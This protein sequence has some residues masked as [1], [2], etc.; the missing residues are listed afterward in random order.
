V[1]AQL[2][3]VVARIGASFVVLDVGG[4]GYRV[5]VPLSVLESLPKTGEKVLLLT[6]TLVREDD[7]SLYG[8][9]EEI[10]LKVFELLLTVSGVGPKVALAMLSALRAEEVARAV[11]SDDVKTLTRVPGIGPKVAQRLVLELRERLQA[12]G[13]ERRVEAIAAQANNR[14]TGGAAPIVEDV[15][16][17]LVNLGYSKSESQRATDSALSEKTKNSSAVDFTGLFR[18]ALNQL[19]GQK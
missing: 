16:S 17:A 13:F 19:T 9:L 1:I 10:E 3:G 7:L 4:V 11:G 5:N 18:S 12:L 2:N 8:F 14:Q 6:H 15:V